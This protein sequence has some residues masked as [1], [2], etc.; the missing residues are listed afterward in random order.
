MPELQVAWSLGGRGIGPVAARVTR[1]GPGAYAVR[2]APLPVTGEWTATVTIR[3]TAID[4]TITTLGVR[5]R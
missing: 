2:F 1:A 4:E 3:T 5:L